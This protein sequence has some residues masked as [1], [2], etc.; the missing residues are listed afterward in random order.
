V[1]NLLKQF[2][3]LLPEP[4]LLTGEVTAIN[5]ELRT[6]TLPD[7]ATITA[8]GDAAMAAMSLRPGLHDR[9]PRAPSCQLIQI[10]I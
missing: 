3:S 4:P 7:G 6:I 5:G 10:V 9:G 1:S 8:R 2:R